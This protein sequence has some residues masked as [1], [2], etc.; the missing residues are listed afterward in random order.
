MAQKDH[1]K[2]NEQQND[3]QKQ[4]ASLEIP[5]QFLFSCPNEGCVKTYQRHS[6]LEKHLE[7]GKCQLQL[8]KETLLDKAK[9]SYQG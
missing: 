2:P 1:R 7:V 9:T 6:N 5:S 4:A 3:L 8:E